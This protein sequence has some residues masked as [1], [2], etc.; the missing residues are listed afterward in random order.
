M[1][2]HNYSD[3]SL[4]SLYS[5]SYAYSWQQDDIVISTNLEF[6]LH[7]IAPEHDQQWKDNLCVIE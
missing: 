1:T 7:T 6:L 3:K 5:F 2:A 4:F